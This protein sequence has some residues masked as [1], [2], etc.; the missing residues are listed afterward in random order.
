MGMSMT[1]NNP[2]IQATV[3]NCTMVS[4]CC[5]GSAENGSPVAAFNGQD[6][7]DKLTGQNF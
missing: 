4:A 6:G 7:T 2:A 3:L 5:G 1:E